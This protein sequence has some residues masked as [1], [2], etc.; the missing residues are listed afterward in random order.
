MKQDLIQRLI[1]CFGYLGPTNNQIPSKFAHRVRPDFIHSSIAPCIL[2]PGQKLSRNDLLDLEAGIFKEYRGPTENKHPFFS[3]LG[4][5]DGS[6]A[7]VAK[8]AGWVEFYRDAIEHFDSFIE[9]KASPDGFFFDRGD[10]RSDESLRRRVNRLS[11][12][13]FKM[14]DE[15]VDTLNRIVAES[16]HRIFGVVAR[17]VKGEDV[18]AGLVMCQGD[19]GFFT[20]GAVLESHR[21]LGLWRHL[22]RLRQELSYDAGVRHWFYNTVNPRIAHK[23]DRS[24][25]MVTY[26]RK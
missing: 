2:R 19:S 18:G 16:P 22:S 10:A 17:D 13:V 23:G 6:T 1:D 12:V 20:A 11:Q 3:V 14:P 26:F 21:G 9:A 24:T 4:R 15:L 5:D 25:E 7:E 8:A